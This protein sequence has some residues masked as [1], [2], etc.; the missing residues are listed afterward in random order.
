MKL[1]KTIAVGTLAL[2]ALTACDRRTPEPNTNGAGTV[3]RE[4]ALV[5]ISGTA[6]NEIDTT[7]SSDENTSTGSGATSINDVEE[8]TAAGSGAASDEVYDTDEE[9]KDEEMN[10]E[11]LQKQEEEYT[12]DAMDD[13]MEMEEERNLRYLDNTSSE[14]DLTPLDR[15]IPVGKEPGFIDNTSSEGNPNQM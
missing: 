4:E 10:E 1:I 11:D 14:S 15:G 3:Q 7:D 5:P 6:A 2:M 12:G 8:D 13:S 9:W